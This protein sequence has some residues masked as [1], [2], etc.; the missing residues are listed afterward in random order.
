M[1]KEVDH[2]LTFLIEYS[3]FEERRLG[4]IVVELILKD[5][6]ANVIDGVVESGVLVVN[7]DEPTIVLSYED[8]I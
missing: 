6:V 2:F 1:K 4:H 8:V 3:E 7:E 5:V